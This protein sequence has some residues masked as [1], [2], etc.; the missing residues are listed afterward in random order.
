MMGH[1]DLPYE[2]Q[3]KRAGTHYWEVIAAFSKQGSAMDYAVRCKRN[4]YLDV[5]HEFNYRVEKRTWSPA[6]CEMEVIWTDT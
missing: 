1:P 2:V 5:S 3:M 6:T 4:N